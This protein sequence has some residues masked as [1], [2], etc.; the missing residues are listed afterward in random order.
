[1]EI[2]EVV[3]E[4]YASDKRKLDK[5][6]EEWY[7][8]KFGD[9][10]FLMSKYAMIE[11]TA[12]KEAMEKFKDLICYEPP[13]MYL[14]FDGDSVLTDD[15]R[16][17]PAEIDGNKLKW[18]ELIFLHEDAQLFKPEDY[19]L[20]TKEDGLSLYLVK[21]SNDL[22][23]YKRDKHYTALDYSYIT[24]TFETEKPL[25]KETYNLMKR[26]YYYHNKAKR[27][28]INGRKDFS[29]IEILDDK[30]VKVYTVEN[31]EEHRIIAIENAE[32]VKVFGQ[33]IAI[34]GNKTYIVMDHNFYL[35]IESNVIEVGNIRKEYKNKLRI[36]EYI[37]P[38]MVKVLRK[39]TCNCGFGEDIRAGINI[40]P[41]W[42]SGERNIVEIPSLDSEIIV[43]KWIRRAEPIDI[44]AK[45]E[46]YTYEEKYIDETGKTK[47]DII[48][49][50]EPAKLN[51]KML[52]PELVEEKIYKIRQFINQ[53]AVIK[54][55]I[56]Y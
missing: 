39:E 3:L 36:Y 1:M 30:D 2:K 48:R 13:K 7:T 15:N 22:I 26:L 14:Y 4:A 53:P 34:K 11:F 21:N 54:E 12:S 55:D 42:T 19:T 33:Y 18:S 52:E 44:E 49:F 35:P 8:V 20:L 24:A 41:I 27:I 32:L 6:E 5:M 28:W 40:R 50:S 10:K 25:N 9:K 16:Y 47:L 38:D 37:I 46:K 43:R 29:G 45:L 23:I 51:C 31:T 17:L 56:E